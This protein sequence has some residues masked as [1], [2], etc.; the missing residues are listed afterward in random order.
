MIT[1]FKH[2]LTMSGQ[3][4]K[5]LSYYII[6]VQETSISFPHMAAIPFHLPELSK[7]LRLIMVFKPWAICRHVMGVCE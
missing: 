5:G 6:N 3:I 1:A 2:S 4:E 7:V